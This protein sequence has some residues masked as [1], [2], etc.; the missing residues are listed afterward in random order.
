[1]FNNAPTVN[2][3]GIPDELRA[4]PQWVTWRYETREGKPT[5]VPYDARAGHRASATDPATW[6]TFGEAFAAFEGRGNF[7]GVG[8]VLASD[9]PYVAVDLDNCID[10]DGRLAP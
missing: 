5:K 8:Y 3:D 7:H 2:V 10:D 1:M 4:R 9:D 6:A